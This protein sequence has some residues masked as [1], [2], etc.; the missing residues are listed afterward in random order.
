VDR[1]GRSG[2]TGNEHG[3]EHS[4]RRD[5]PR[6]FCPQDGPPRAE[7]HVDRDVRAS[8]SVSGQPMRQSWCRTSRNTPAASQISLA[9]RLLARRGARAARPCWPRGANGPA[10]ASRLAGLPQGCRDSC[11]VMEGR[12]GLVAAFFTTRRK[13]SRSQAPTP[14]RT[15]RRELAGA[16]LWSRGPGQDAYTVAMDF[17]DSRWTAATR[18]R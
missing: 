1:S 14:R 2:A 8:T 11:L 3:D 4:S 6:S 17:G 13:N 18:E 15:S 16:L 12:N 7:S 5:G 10:T 9:Q